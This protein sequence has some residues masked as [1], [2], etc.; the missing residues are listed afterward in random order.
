MDDT[1]RVCP[2]ILRR[3]L[4][5]EREVVA[6]AD[7]D[8]PPALIVPVTGEAVQVKGA[9]TQR[10]GRGTHHHAHREGPSKV[11]LPRDLAKNSR[12]AGGMRY[13][14]CNLLSPL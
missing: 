5:P 4:N 13:L 10:W 3:L 9:G 6:M 11:S 14:H 12:R 8:G 7:M 2:H 1:Y